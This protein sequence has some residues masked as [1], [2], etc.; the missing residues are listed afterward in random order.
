MLVHGHAGTLVSWKFHVAC[1]GPRICRVVGPFSLMVAWGGFA[2]S[3][4]CLGSSMS[5]FF[6][7][8]SHLCC[9]D[10]CLEAVVN[11]LTSV[12]EN[13]GLHIMFKPFLYCFLQYLA[14]T[15][16]FCCTS[17]YHCGFV[18]YETNPPELQC[19][20]LNMTTCL[21]SRTSKATVSV[22][23]LSAVHSWH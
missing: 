10:L 3:V 11:A 17:V 19:D 8:V 20:R 16:S 1:E 22:T 9:S 5:T 14:P 21:P 15:N 7:C 4:R 2:H 18:R 23:F 13:L 12:I 6:P